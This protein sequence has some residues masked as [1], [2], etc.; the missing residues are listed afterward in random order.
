MENNGE[1]TTPN[2]ESDSLEAGWAL[3]R[4]R[5]KAWATLLLIAVICFGVAALLGWWG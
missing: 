3:L 5:L 4:G 1:N 2:T